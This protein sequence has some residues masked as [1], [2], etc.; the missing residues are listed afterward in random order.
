MSLSLFFAK[1]SVRKAAIRELDD[2]RTLRSSFN[3]MQLTLPINLLLTALCTAYI[4]FFTKP[5][6]E[7]AYF[8]P[9]ILCWALALA[10]ECYLEVYYVYMV[11][12]KDLTPRLTLETVGVLFKTLLLWALLTQEFHLFSFAASQLAYNLLLLV[13]YPYLIA[14]RPKTVENARIPPLEELRI[15]KGLPSRREDDQ[16]PGYFKPYVLDTHSVL[17]A[18]FTK[19][20]VLKF[21]LQEGE[22]IFMILYESQMA[23]G[24]ADPLKLQAEFSLVSNFLGLLIQLLFAPAEETALILFSS[25]KAPD[26]KALSHWLQI[27]L[28]LGTLTI[29]GS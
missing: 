14:R 9:S 27:M 5:S 18:D 29:I 20:S 15:V 3:M 24:L 26:L 25:R 12:T 11:L 21:I 8:T 19:S 23:E 6:T 13:G 4:I 7:L 16:T 2:N 28:A 10:V 22:K 17:L 1:E